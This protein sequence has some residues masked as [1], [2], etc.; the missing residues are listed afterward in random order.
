MITLKDVAR[1]SG[2]NVGTVSRI[3]NNRGYIKEETREKVY[4]AMERLD[5]QP[6]EIARSLSKQ[7]NNIIGIIVPH[8]RHPY[9]AEMISCLEQATYNCNYKM[10][11]FNSGGRDEKEDEYIEMCKQNRVA[12]II[13]FSSSF[14]TKKF[15]KLDFPLVTIERF[16]DYGTASIECDNYQGGVLAAEHL[17]SRKCRNILCFGSIRDEPMPADQRI[18][19]TTDVCTRH[20]VQCVVVNVD[21]KLYKELDYYDIICSTLKKYPE[22]DGIF[23]N[24]DLLASQIIQVCAKQGISVPEQMKIVGFDDTIISQLTTPKITVIQQP[25]KEMAKAAISSIISSA[26]GATIPRRCVFPVT[27]VTRGST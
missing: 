23:A 19:G 18:H 1:E 2:L 9:F 5:Y 7:K 16:L 27:L 26:S 12:G 14:K 25:V 4:E 15:R 11:L 13:L 22:V 20:G 3:L 24:S 8:I 17:I 6:N 21:Q 10:L